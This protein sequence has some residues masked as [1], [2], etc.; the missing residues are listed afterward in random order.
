MCNC[1]VCN[2][3]CAVL[4]KLTANHCSAN[5]ENAADLGGWVPWTTLMCKVCNLQSAVMLAGCRGHR[6]NIN[7]A[8]DGEHC[9]AKRSAHTCV[10]LDYR[11]SQEQCLWPR[12]ITQTTKKYC[13][14]V[15]SSSRVSD[16]GSK[17]TGLKCADR[18]ISDCA[19]QY[20]AIFLFVAPP[21]GCKG[22]Y[23]LG[24]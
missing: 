12:L 3:R 17:S 24:L 9:L 10:R 5:A 20:K 19:W 11:I 22:M 14:A 8:K 4:Y 13:T 15:C 23:L 7:H 21:I 2:L 16:Q 18:K 1:A 6:N